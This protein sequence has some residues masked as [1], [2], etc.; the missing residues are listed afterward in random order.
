V[1]PPKERLPGPVQGP[2]KCD[3]VEERAYEDRLEQLL[4]A[5]P[6]PRSCRVPERSSRGNTKN[7][8]LPNGG[9]RAANMVNKRVDS[10]A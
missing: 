10:M 6:F 5:S 7:C 1:L 4:R 2:R 3:Y 8:S 9:N